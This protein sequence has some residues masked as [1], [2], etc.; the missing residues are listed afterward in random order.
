[1]KEI[2]ADMRVFVDELVARIAET[3]S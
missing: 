3:Y 2:V 1:M